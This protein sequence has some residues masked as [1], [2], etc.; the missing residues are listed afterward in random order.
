MYRKAELQLKNTK[1]E[2]QASAKK[3]S[4]QQFFDTIDTQEV[5]EQLDPLLLGLER[6]DWKPKMVEHEIA[7]RKHIADMRCKRSTDLVDSE[8]LDRRIRAIRALVSFCKVQEPVAREDHPKGTVGGISKTVN[9]VRGKRRS[10][11]PSHSPA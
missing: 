9:H 5:N 11:H 4:R 8:R 10:R 1:I 7:E 6:K 2:L 3:K